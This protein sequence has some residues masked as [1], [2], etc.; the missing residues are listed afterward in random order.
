MTRTDTS[1]VIRNGKFSVVVLWTHAGGGV[2]ECILSPGGRDDDGRLRRRRQTALRVAQESG[3]SH[4]PRPV[5]RTLCC[6]ARP[7]RSRLEIEKATIV[8]AGL[9]TIMSRKCRHRSQGTHPR[10]AAMLWSLG[11]HSPDRSALS[12]AAVAE[13]QCESLTRQSPRRS[14]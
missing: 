13:T 12:P 4:E 2:G 7:S 14:A 5:S 10:L 6:V 3:V 1:N 11:A 9:H 8:N